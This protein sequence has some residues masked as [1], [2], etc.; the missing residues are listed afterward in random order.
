MRGLLRFVVLRRLTR[1]M[2]GGW[3]A[4]VLASPTAW[5]LARRAARALKEGYDRRRGGGG[6]GGGAGP[7]P[8][9]AV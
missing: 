8:A 2:P 5:R 4:W 1:F 7:P 3:I 6:R 9:P